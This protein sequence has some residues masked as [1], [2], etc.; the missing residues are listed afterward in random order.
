MTIFNSLPSVLQHFINIKQYKHSFDMHT[1]EVFLLHLLSINIQSLKLT[2]LYT[3]SNTNFGMTGLPK[4]VYLECSLPLIGGFR[5]A[6]FAVT[7]SHLP[8]LAVAE[9]EDE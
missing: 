2:Q 1:F 9:T 7:F 6:L 8:F 4:I 3:G 5:K